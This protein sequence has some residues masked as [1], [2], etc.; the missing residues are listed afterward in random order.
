MRKQLVALAVL[1]GLTLLAACT[2]PYSP[3]QR[4]LGGAAIGAGTGAVIGGIAGG[5]QGAGLGALI[6]GAV[7][8]AGGA[9]TTPQRPRP[10]Y[11]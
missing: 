8:A 7:G 4:A 3:G 9:A 2:D 11:Q 6:G 10:Y 5:G 1:S